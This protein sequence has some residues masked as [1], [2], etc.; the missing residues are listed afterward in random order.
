MGKKCIPSW[1]M[2][3]IFLCHIARDNIT[4]VISKWGIFSLFLSLIILFSVLSSTF[5]VSHVKCNS[6]LNFVDIHSYW[7][8]ISQCFMFSM[9]YSKIILNI[10]RR[11]WSIRKFKIVIPRRSWWFKFAF[12]YMTFLHFFIYNNWSNVI[13]KQIDHPSLNLFYLND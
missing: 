2:L 8:V 1:H 4:S 3:L 10:W 13:T 7:W 9:I 11:I 12:F 6:V 5:F